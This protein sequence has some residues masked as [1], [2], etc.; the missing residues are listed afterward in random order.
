M[1]SPSNASNNNLF[2]YLPEE[3]LQFVP[4]PMRLKQQRVSLHSFCLWFVFGWKG[5]HQ[6]IKNIKAE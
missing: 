5:F 4:P 3:I 1:Q 2:L 6:I